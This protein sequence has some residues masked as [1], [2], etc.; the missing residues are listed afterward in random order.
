[1]GE[2]GLGSQ[3]RL[4]EGG[5]DCSLCFHPMFAVFSRREA[6][7]WLIFN[8]KNQVHEGQNIDLT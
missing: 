3:Q 8:E 5:F 1:M 4:I 6:N 2:S 7:P